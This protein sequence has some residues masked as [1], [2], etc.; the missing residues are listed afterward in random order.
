M[1]TTTN[2]AESVHDNPKPR[3]RS[4]GY[5]VPHKEWSE[6]HKLMK[7]MEG[8]GELVLLAGDPKLLPEIRSENLAAALLTYSE[9][10]KR[11]LDKGEPLR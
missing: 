10:G 7:A 9:H 6:L 8:M 5:L 1:A 2:R 4:T 3:T 11:L